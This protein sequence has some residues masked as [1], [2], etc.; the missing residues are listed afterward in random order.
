VDLQAVAASTPGLV[1]ADLANVVYEAALLA[2]RKGKQE[3]EMADF[4]EAIERVVAGL[5]KKNRLLNET[6]KLIVAFHECGHAVVSTAVPGADP[7]R[8]I[9]IIPRG[10]SALGYTLQMPTE[11]RYLLT[12]SELL[13]KMAGLL[14]GRIAEEIVFQE[15]STGAQNDLQ[16]ATDIAQRN[17]QNGGA[18]N[19]RK[20]SAK[21]S[22]GKGRH[23]K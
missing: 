19:K 22:S 20:S 8:K 12:K 9:S 2:A 14:G 3:V 1:G 18:A 23:K 21:K 11:D 5:Q 4:N 10:I 7:V 17:T 6:E 13:G 15:V 16:R